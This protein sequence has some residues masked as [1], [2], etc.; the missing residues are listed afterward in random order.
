VKKKKIAA[1]SFLNARPIT[2]GLEHGLGDDR[3]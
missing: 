2:H 3:F 1:V